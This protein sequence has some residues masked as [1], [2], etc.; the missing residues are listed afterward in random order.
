MKLY[1]GINVACDKCNF[2]VDDYILVQTFS[3]VDDPPKAEFLCR[4]CADEKGLPIEYDGR[5][6]KTIG[7][8]VGE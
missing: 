4:Q 3:I 7:L 8:Y 5:T 2:I 6:V 1:S